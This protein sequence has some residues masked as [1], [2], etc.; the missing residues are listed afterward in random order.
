[1]NRNK[2]KQ[3]LDLARDMS[4]AVSSSPLLGLVYTI[5]KLISKMKLTTSYVIINLRFHTVCFVLEYS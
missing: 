3:N 5:Y 1:M 4:L 2:G